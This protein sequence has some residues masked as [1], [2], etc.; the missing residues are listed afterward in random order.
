MSNKYNY[1]LIIIIII[2]ILIDYLFLKNNWKIKN[3]K[4]LNYLSSLIF[5]YTYFILNW[6]K[7]DWSMTWDG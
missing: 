5:T 6:L 4:S 1:I 3:T 7:V 2:L